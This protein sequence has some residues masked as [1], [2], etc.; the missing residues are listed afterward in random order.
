MVAML[1]AFLEA[2]GARGIEGSWEY[3]IAAGTRGI[4][5]SWEYRIAAGARGIEGSWE[6]S[7][8]I[9]ISC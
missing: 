7:E 4:E 6:Y 5:G 8:S 2:A 3:R 9:L 1:G